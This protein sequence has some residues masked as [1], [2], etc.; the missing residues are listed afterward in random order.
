[1]HKKLLRFRNPAT[2]S[3]LPSSTLRNY[4]LIWPL[5]EG[6]TY[7]LGK[8]CRKQHENEENWTGVRASKILL[9]RYVTELDFNSPA[10]KQKTY[11]VLTS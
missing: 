9:C 11:F 4:N 6:A 2:G 3:F 10:M 7:Y 5:Q 8:I 1:M